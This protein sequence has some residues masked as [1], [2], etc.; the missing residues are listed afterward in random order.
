[1]R[2]LRYLF[3]TGGAL[4]LFL[5]GTAAMT[6]QAWTAGRTLNKLQQA[7]TVAATRAFALHAARYKAG[8]G[9][10]DAVYRWSLRWR[11]SGPG[12]KADAAHLV[13]MKKLATGVKV[14]HSAGMASAADAAAAR[15]YIAEAELWGAGGR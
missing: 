4:A 12:R 3:I 10:L 11:L 13:R 7:R 14:K 8:Q 9:T 1:M 5:G 2:H 15:Y 6:G